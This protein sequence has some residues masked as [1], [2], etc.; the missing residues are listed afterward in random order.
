MSN[1]FGSPNDTPRNSFYGGQYTAQ[2]PAVPDKNNRSPPSAFPSF[3]FQSHAGNPDPGTH[4]PGIGRRE[5]LDSLA[6]RAQNGQV[7]HTPGNVNPHP[8][9]PPTPGTVYPAGAAP[10]G[11]GLVEEGGEDLGRPYAPFMGDVPERSQTPP[12]PS[13]ASQLYRGSA[14]AAAAGKGE[15]GHDN[16]H[17]LPR[18]GSTAQISMRAP[19]LSPAS[20]PTSSLWAPP[21][22]PYAYQGSG[23]STALNGYAASGYGQYSSYADIQAQLRK[24]KPIMASTRIPQKLTPEDKPWTTTKDGRERASYW[25]TLV[26]IIAGI[27][28]AAVLCYFTWVDTYLLADSQVCSYFYDDFSNGLDTTNTWTP[29]NQLGGFGNGEFQITRN[30]QTNLHVTNGELYITPTLVSDEI[31]GGYPAILDGGS[32]DLG[33]QCST[34]NTTACSVQ[35]SNSSGAVVN[36]VFSSRISTQ[37]HYAIQYGKVEVVAK[38][39]QG[40]WLWPA[41]W[42]LPENTTYGAWPL[43]GEID[44][45]EARGNPSSYAAQGVNYVRGSLN[46]G[47][48]AALYTT[49]F[50]WWSLKQSTFADDFH[51][52]TLEWT[53][54]FMRIYVDTRLDAMLTIKIQGKGGKSFWSRGNYPQTAQNG[55]SQVVVEDVWAKNGGGPAAPFDQPFYLILDVAVGGTSGWFPDSVGGKPWYDG[56]NTAMREFAEAQSTWYSTW[57]SSTD[58]RSFRV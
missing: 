34:D 51:T 35:A 17:G 1:P 19:F 48:L 4:I 18:T 49:V 20:R 52:Y 30:D 40:D 24:S 10:G 42:M 15:Y 12:T 8:L 26:G 23:S 16:G 7:L 47:P 44:M 33:D 55:S 37:G 25:L 27:A 56:S 45:M 9:S 31:D 5:S 21:S 50:G 3:P 14:A 29:D 46:Y 38:I 53:E 58:D 11:Y 36:P 54:D 28:G 22:F 2:A 13:S 6:A 57:P 39:P 41:I 32:F 43:S